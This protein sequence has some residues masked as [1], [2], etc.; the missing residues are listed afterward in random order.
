MKIHWICSYLYSRNE[1]KGKCSLEHTLCNLYMKE[2]QN[3][4]KFSNKDE[5]GTLDKYRP[6]IFLHNTIRPV[7]RLLDFLKRRYFQAHTNKRAWA[8]H[9]TWVKWSLGFQPVMTVVNGWRR[10]GQSNNHNQ[11]ILVNNL[12][13]MI[14]RTNWHNWGFCLGHIALQ[15]SSHRSL[16][17]LT[18]FFSLCIF[19]QWTSRSPIPDAERVTMCQI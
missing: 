16:K 17:Q 8:V 15:H 4:E 7:R 12:T 2:N 9:T 1:D 14:P 18:K 19:H 10:K 5:P 11:G 3:L 6:I 13:Y